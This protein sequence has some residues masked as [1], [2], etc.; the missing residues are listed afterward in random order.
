MLQV[1]R[2]VEEAKANHTKLSAEVSAALGAILKAESK[3][4]VLKEEL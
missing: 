2:A 3:L 1:N 4:K